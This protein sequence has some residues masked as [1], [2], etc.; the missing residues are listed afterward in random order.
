M[1]IKPYDMEVKIKHL[2][3]TSMQK[4]SHKWNNKNKRDEHGMLHADAL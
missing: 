2:T 4:N 3:N 1:N